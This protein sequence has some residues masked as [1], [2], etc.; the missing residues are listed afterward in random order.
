[1]K[2]P[3]VFQG[4]DLGWWWCFAKYRVWLK[5]VGHQGES[6][7]GG[8]YPASSCHS[9]CFLS[10]WSELFHLVTLFLP[11]HGAPALHEPIHSGAKTSWANTTEPWAVQSVFPSSE[12]CSRYYV[13]GILTQGRPNPR[14]TSDASVLFRRCREVGAIDFILFH[15]SLIY[16][17][18]TAV[19]P[20]SFLLSLSRLT[21]ASPRY[22]LQCNPCFTSSLKRTDLPWYQPNEP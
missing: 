13:T 20:S 9:F 21:S 17:I 11:L 1:M 2:C 5:A 22:N 8:P 4:W 7:K 12:C 10:P 6:G 14:A 19:S 18:P 16:Y 15:S 3:H